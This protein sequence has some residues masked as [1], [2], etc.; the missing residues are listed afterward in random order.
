MDYQSINNINTINPESAEVLGGIIIASVIIWLIVLAYCILVNWK[1]YA[2][3]DEPGWACLVPI[4]NVCVLSKIATGSMVKWLLC[5]IPL[6]GPFYALYLEY[7]L[8]KSFDRGF[9]FF[10]GMLFLSPIFLGILAF[11]S[12]EYI[13]PQ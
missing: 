2:K 8:C 6:F 3:A 12:S 1:I 9:G 4:Y 13:G 5:L 7:K 11:G 10:L